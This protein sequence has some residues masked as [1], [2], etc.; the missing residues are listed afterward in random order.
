VEDTDGDMDYV[1]VVVDQPGQGRY[2]TDYI[3]VDP[4]DQNHLKGFL[5]WNT[6]RSKGAALKEGTQ[7]TLR[8][9]IIDKAVNESN[10]VVFPFTFAS[11]F[12]DHEALPASF[13]EENI[14]RLGL[15]S[16][17]LISPDSG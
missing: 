13:D 1:A 12:K 2:P 4:Q 6:H 10:E 14:P 16:I 8:V 5:Q 11:G 17:D 3:L 15:I 7:I 9:S